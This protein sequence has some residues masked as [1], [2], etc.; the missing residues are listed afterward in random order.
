MDYV[1]GE[2]SS[3]PGFF[4]PLMHDFAPQL[5]YVDRTVF[6]LPTTQRILQKYPHLSPIIIDDPKE[7]KQPIQHTAA[8]KELY[9]AEFKGQAIKSC[10]GMGDYVCCLYY[11]IALVSDCHLECTYCILQDY[12]RNNPR[13]T[14]YCNTDAVFAS[15]KEKANKHP[16]KLLRVGTGE[17]S[18]SLALDHIHEFS[19]DI[20]RFANEHPNVLIELK[21]KTNNI[22]NL[23]DLEHNRR[24]VVSWSVNPESYITREEHKCA[25][26]KDRL[27]A[28]RECADAKYPVAFHLDP[29]LH[30]ENWQDE[31]RGVI[32]AIATKFSP[33]EMAWVSIGSL[34]FTPDLKKISK[35][36][37]PTSQ[38]MSGE[39]FPSTD[40][41]VRYLKSI[42]EE[43]YSFIKTEIET[44]LK[45]VPFYLCME[46]KTVWQ[47]VFGSVPQTN[48]ELEK[49]LTVNF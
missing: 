32:D 11:T 28:A 7:I 48:R 34:R 22:G 29:L 36:R 9:L 26:L 21:T 20:V 30:L 5:I 6:S 46:T 39:L 42:R 38:V 16:E 2:L 27:I 14:F 23:L 3:S 40:G 31:Y 24:T 37:F 1:P 35:G 41:K 4:C 8:K 45:K 12:L 43:M 10:Q 25:T 17:L 15:I 13:I 19:K 49:K 44:K 33:K 18:D 47:N